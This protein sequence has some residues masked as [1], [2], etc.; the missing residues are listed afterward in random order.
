MAYNEGK[1]T[2]TVEIG[3]STRLRNAQNGSEWPSW[4]FCC[5][6]SNLTYDATVKRRFHG[7]RLYGAG[8]R[9]DERQLKG[10]MPWSSDTT[11]C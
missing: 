10:R 9:R 2:N 4:A 7:S 11:S 8:N 1:R 6:G 3:S 5:I